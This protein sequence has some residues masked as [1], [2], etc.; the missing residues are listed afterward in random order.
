MPDLVETIILELKMRRFFL[1]NE[2]IDTIYFGGGT[3]SL[4][5]AESLKHI[6][7]QIYKT[8]KVANNAEITLEANPDDITAEKVEVWTNAGINRL[9]IGVQSFDELDLLWMNRSHNAL[10]ALE[11]I[12]LAKNGGIDNISIDLIYALPNLTDTAWE[13]NI[14]MAVETGIQHI[15][16]YSLTM[17][18]KTLLSH[19]V[20]TGQNLPPDEDQSARQFEI[21]MDKLDFY[22]FEHY[23]I[24]N[25]SIPGF[26]SRHNSSYWQGESYLGIGPSAHSF[27]GK[28]RQWNVSSNAAYISG[29]KANIP[30]T[31]TE[32]LTE[33]EKHNELLLTRLRVREGLDLLDFKAKFGEEPFQNLLEN[34]KPYLE[35]DCLVLFE[36]RL[37]STRKGKFI[38]DDISSS[39]FWVEKSSRI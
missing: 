14:R 12:R 7:H 11:S 10:Q 37:R 1:R 21:V 31:E 13:K 28:I 18:E 9:S 5:D 16:C 34:A 6:F 4:L 2:K 39:L 17:E 32:I 36:N 29:I 23:E 35:A 24:S 38:A 3:P 19:K 20:K 26:R 8:H 25:F 15:S 30:Q 22:G 33:A 27:D